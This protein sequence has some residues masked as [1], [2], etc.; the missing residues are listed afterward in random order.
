MKPVRSLLFT[1]LLLALAGCRLS[2][3]GYVGENSEGY[4]SVKGR[5]LVV[6]GLNLT[7]WEDLKDGFVITVD[8]PGCKVTLQQGEAKRSR[9]ELAGGDRIIHGGDADYLLSTLAPNQAAAESAKFGGTPQTGTGPATG[10]ANGTTPPP[11]QPE[12]ADPDAGD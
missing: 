9:F 8:D 7:K 5:V 10:A 11:S 2:A 1:T 6:E 4:F 3:E 12:V